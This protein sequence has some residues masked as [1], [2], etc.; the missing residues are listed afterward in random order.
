MRSNE[1]KARFFRVMMLGLL[2]GTM[3]LAES[4]WA[5]QRKFLVIL[6][7]SPKQFGGAAVP[8]GGLLNPQSVTDEYFDTINPGID[9]FA[10]YWKEISY[11]DVT[12]S[13]RVTDW[14]LLPW[15]IQ[16]QQPMSYVDLNDNSQPGFVRRYNYGHGE[17]FNNQLSMVL[18]NIGRLNDPN[19]G[20]GAM[21][22]TSAGTP[23]YTPGERFLD[24]PIPPA[25]VG[26]G[27]WD[28]FDE[29]TNSMDWGRPGPPFN[30]N[31]IDDLPD[32]PGPWIDLNG[33]GL[34][35]NPVGCIY[36][37]DSDNDGN[38]DC[39]PNGPG[40]LGCAGFNPSNPDAPNV[41]PPTRLTAAVNPD[42]ADCNGNL[43]PDACDISC[44]SQACIATGWT[45][46]CGTST[47]ELPYQNQGTECVPGTGNQVP[48]ECQFANVTV[49]CVD[50]EVTDEDDGCFGHP[51]CEPL[52]AQY[53]RTTVPRC[54]YADV[55]GNGRLDIVE[56]FENFLHG[57]PFARP[58]PFPPP[59]P[60]PELYSTWTPGAD[61]DTYVTNNYPGT[62]PA[63]VVSRKS[64]RLIGGPHDPLNKI[65]VPSQRLCADGMPYRT[66]GSQANVC[67]AGVHSEYNPPDS[68]VEIGSTKMSIGALL[69]ITTPVPGWFA[70]AW[71]NRYENLDPPPWTSAAKMATPFNTG[72]RPTF[73]PNRGGTGGLG[74]G[75]LAGVNLANARIL[76]DELNGVGLPTIAFDGP[77]EHDDL[78]S[79]KYHR[80]G[81]QHL[82]EVTSPF[83]TNIWGHDRGTN[84]P[85]GF[86]SPDKIIPAAGP[87]ATQL[88][89][90]LGR[91]G[92]NVL[93][94]EWLTWRTEPPF[95]TGTAWEA[96]Y[97]PHPY[98]GRNCTGGV[99]GFRDF[100]LDGLVDQGE[101][102]TPGRENYVADPEAN[103][104]RGTASV[105]P[106]NR[107]RLMEDCIEVLD[108]AIDFDSF[109]D[110]VAMNA[111]T[112][113]GGGI[114]RPLPAP[115]DLQG[116]VE[117]AG[118]CSGIVLLP[119]GSH[120]PLDFLGATSF[121]HP[122]LYP[123]HNDDGLNDPAYTYAQFPTT[124]TR[125]LNWSLLFHDLVIDLGTSGEGPVGTGG[126]QSRYA[127][128]EWL[129]TW[130]HFPDL[131][132]YDI[133][134]LPNAIENCPVGA[135]DI[136]AD[137]GFVHPTPILKE[138][139]C[140][141]WVEPVD[142]TTV[143]TPGVDKTITL[144]VAEFVR[145][146]SYFFF[147]NED[148][149]GERYYFWSAGRGFD[150]NMPGEGV[151]IMH[152][153][154]GSNPDALPQQQRSGNRPQYLIV[155]ADGKNDLLTCV[156]RGDDGDPW[157]GSS[158]NTLFDCSTLPASQWYADN[159]CTGLEVLD[160]LEDGTGSAR[161]TFN[162]TPTSIPS[163]KFVDPPGGVTV[164]TI[165]QIR[166][167]TN[168]V[169]GGTSIRF[170]YKRQDAG[171]PE[172][173]GSTFIFP[174]IKKPSPG[175]ID[176]STN[177]DISGVP[178]GRYF[179]FADLIPGVGADGTEAK[180]TRPRAGR[181][182]QGTATLGL[183]DVIVNVTTVAGTTVTNQGT[184]RSETWTIECV[185]GNAGKWYV[186]SSLTQPLPVEKPTAALCTANPTKCATTG[187]QYTS[188]GGAVKFTIQQGAGSSP[189]GA[190]DDTFTFT[191]TGIT[192][193]SA[194]VTIVNG[195]IS[196]DPVAVIEASPLSGPPP[197]E[198]TFDARLSVDPNGQPL[199]FQW[200]FGDG[201]N[202]TG[203]LTSHIYPTP[204]PNGGPYTVTLKATN[205]LNGRFGE[206]SVDIRVTNNTP[207]AKI[208]AKPVSGPAPLTVKLSASESSDSE[209][210]ENQLIYQ[211][212]YGDGF[213]A[214]DAGTPGVQRDVEHTYSRVNT[215][216][217]TT[218]CTATCPCTPT[219]R[220][221]TAACPCSFTAVLTV[222][223]VGGQKDTDFVVI[224]VGNTN[225]VAV[226]TST[227]LQGLG[228]LSVTFN[229]KG[230]TDAENDKL[231]V[232][233]MWDDSSPNEK[234]P[235]LTG[236]PPATDGSVGHTFVLPAGASEKKYLVKAIV[237]DLKADG[238]PKGGQA[239]AQFEVIVYS[240]ATLPPLPNHPPV[241][242]FCIE[243]DEVC[244]EAFLVEAIVGDV[245]TFDASLSSDLDTPTG[246]ILSYRWTFGDGGQTNFTTNPIATHTYLSTGDYSARLTVRDAMNASSE[247]TKTVRVL[248]VGSN[249]NPVALIATGPRSGPAP[250]SITFD[251]SI[252]YD[253]D[254]E[255]ITSYT[256]EFG[257]E[258]ANIEPR[259][260]SEVTQVFEDPGEYTVMLTVRTGVDGREGSSESQ[261]ITVTEAVT[262]PPPVMP[263][264][265]NGQEPPD[266]ADQRP[267]SSTC[268]FGIL[269]GVLGS[270]LGLTLTAVTRRRIRA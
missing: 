202:G 3:L 75:W 63:A 97:G 103:R 161:V 87:Y 217:D 180:L 59:P 265:P 60:D 226:V 85:G 95:N 138:T 240:L 23:A 82:G 177:W 122:D 203:A 257:P 94:M 93:Q 225:P 118:V 189:K 126:A 121:S 248:L 102:V 207:S 160:I 144:P 49:Q 56:P 133:Y 115:F 196:E 185:D 18:R 268:G 74:S 267:P 151:L 128:H 157:P 270:L 266:S 11:G 92:G 201:S 256:W 70:Q 163:M 171:T 86:G 98:T 123:I 61:Y 101:V 71:R 109:V 243:A 148:L 104:A 183:G 262:Q 153:D 244:S 227:A 51:V 36:L 89:G 218:N 5:A 22:V 247:A 241:A 206:T 252:S 246:D 245:I 159:A 119:A 173:T 188:I 169:F 117:V 72:V 254:G 231:E 38:P 116:P 208:V 90:Q 170:Y 28:G 150:E 233:W 31:S 20:V 14:I 52:A 136:M 81:D 261:T 220:T 214:N 91:D 25:T 239:T 77:V 8:P 55:N 193:P 263:P 67:P 242:R 223:D 48:D 191:T 234:W 172:F 259:T 2:A 9:S 132:D 96:T 221:C 107:R 155:Q 192:A 42:T 79:S 178:N 198:V 199:S 111:V 21:Q 156:N 62:N 147:E 27:A 222:T 182:N 145:D 33:N 211:W 168:D 44:D 210:P 235:A 131:Y 17:D 129:H 69:D 166:T 260:G 140:T 35:D 200:N 149:P 1:L 209:T 216:L 24:I 110:P 219:G 54:E 37:P 251:G 99:C 105:Y 53:V 10:E 232:E 162:W 114:S 181:N 238:T 250:L 127:A 68:W 204:K 29:A 143:L 108:D 190:L 269:M 230:S 179:I 253:P 47:D 154:V 255:V 124:G 146:S 258:V 142:L 41:C 120:I 12:I 73:T 30:Y 64:V 152:T 141:H 7:H 249:R 43:V 186:G 194:A 58:V 229:A 167:E 34:A 88:H 39:C 32:N 139:S 213:G 65:T 212:N 46:A 19:A 264:P 50:M 197:L 112:C 76:P 66:I 40:N 134:D 137:G 236:K 135:W 187:V 184:A 237:R 84:S 6:A 175:F 4:A 26:N 113:G 100:N 13:G 78:P 176:L 205:P 83:S 195:Q 130:E 16:P 45:G 106:W 15:A 224:Q 228:P 125:Q 174:Q 164:G 165:Y 158:E 57:V 80:A 215:N